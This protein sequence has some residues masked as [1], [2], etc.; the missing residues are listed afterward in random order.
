MEVAGPNMVFFSMQ[1]LLW[2]FRMARNMNS[3]IPDASGNGAHLERRIS[4]TG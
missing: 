3:S 4:D 1:L 2:E